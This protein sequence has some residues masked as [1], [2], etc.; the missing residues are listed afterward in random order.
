MKSR[1]CLESQRERR[2]KILRSLSEINLVGGM[3][4][5]GPKIWSLPSWKILVFRH[6]PKPA[7]IDRRATTE[8]SEACLGH[9]RDTSI[10]FR[11]DKSP[12]PSKHGHLSV[13]SHVWYY[14]NQS[15]LNEKCEKWEIH[16]KYASKA[17][18]LFHVT[19]SVTFPPWWLPREASTAAWHEEPHR[20]GWGLVGHTVPLLK[21]QNTKSDQQYFLWKTEV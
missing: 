7:E 10:G 21:Y 1:H 14:K 15:P 20:E 12:R 3:T 11:A 4:K 6:K 17:T 9:P 5:Q 13:I 2:S 16:A 18:R 19:V 8:L